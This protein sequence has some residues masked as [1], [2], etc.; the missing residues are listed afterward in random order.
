MEDR[1]SSV[2]DLHTHRIE[3]KYR[4]ELFFVFYYVVEI[5][6]NINRTVA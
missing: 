1:G 4:T 6:F 3:Q 5:K 2:T